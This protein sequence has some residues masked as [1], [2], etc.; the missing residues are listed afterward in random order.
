MGDP[1]G[2]A[3]P[4]LPQFYWLWSPLNF[5][6]RFMLYHKNADEN[7]IPW[8]TASVLG[9]LGDAAPSHM[10]NCASKISYKQG[11]RHAQGAVLETV[12]ADGGKWEVELTP[13]FQFYMSGIG[14]MHPEWGHGM[15][16]GDNAVG[17]DTYDLATVN[18]NDPRFQH[19][20]AFVTA[21][22]KG[23][24]TECQGAGVLEQLVVGAYKPHGLTGIFD[25][26]P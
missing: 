24:G 5:D 19:V 14:Y 22:L 13:R 4:R 18:E 12:D 10:T 26:A 25:P 8:N 7:G 3:P 20:Q 15:Y 21:K 23:P 11:T 1:Q 17:Y 9:A 16:R 2:V 6:D